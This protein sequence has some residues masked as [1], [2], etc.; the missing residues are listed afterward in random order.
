[1]NFARSL[2]LSGSCLL[3]VPPAY[4]KDAAHMGYMQKAHAAQMATQSL[5]TEPGQ[6]AFGTIHEIVV[7]LETDPKTD[8]SKVNIDALRAHLVDMDNVTL[9][10]KI[11]YEPMAN[12]EH[13]HVSGEGGVRDS[14]QRMVMMH[15]EMASDT[16]DWHMDASQAPDGAHINVTAKSPLG[17]QKMKELGL[18]GMMAEGIHHARHHMM[19]ARGAM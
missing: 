3:F 5:P 16:P 13:I 18:I 11:T 7:M 10:A 6:S 17:L 14:I 8:W 19:L 1:M 15:A 9:H 12:G 4:A 2:L